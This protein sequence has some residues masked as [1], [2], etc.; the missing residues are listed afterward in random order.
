[1]DKS[2]GDSGNGKRTST[3]I[4]RKLNEQCREVVARELNRDRRSA[5]Q[6]AADTGCSSRTVEKW[7][8]EDS[9]PGVPHFFA[10]ARQI[11]GLR[12]QALRWLEADDGA[13][14]DP[15]KVLNEIQRLLQNRKG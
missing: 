11:P 8:G 7:R 1:M 10:L 2:F 4:V 12:E 14:G 6:I 5:K 15:N 3:H 13:G 9:I